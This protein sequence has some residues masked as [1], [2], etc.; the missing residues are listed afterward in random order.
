MPRRFQ[1]MLLPSADPG[2]WTPE[3]GGGL[4]SVSGE[5]PVAPPPLRERGVGGSVI[6]LGRRAPPLPLLDE[7]AGDDPHAVPQDQ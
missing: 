5:G 3:R 2:G 1:A 7:G 4:P 6:S